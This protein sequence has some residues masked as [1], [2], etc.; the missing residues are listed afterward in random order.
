MRSCWIVLIRSVELGVGRV[1]LVNVSSVTVRTA[2]AEVYSGCKFCVAP[3][4]K[5]LTLNGVDKWH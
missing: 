4:G 2:W 3:E 1:E 5:I